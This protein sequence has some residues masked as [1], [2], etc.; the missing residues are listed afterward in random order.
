MDLNEKEKSILNYYSIF[1]FVS[2][3]LCGICLLPCY[4]RKSSHEFCFLASKAYS[5]Y[6]LILYRK[7]FLTTSLGSD[8]RLWTRVL[9][10]AQVPHCLLGRTYMGL[11]QIA[12][13]ILWNFNWYCKKKKRKPWRQFGTVSWT[14]PGWMPATIEHNKTKSTISLNLNKS[15]LPGGKMVKDPLATAGDPRDMGLIPRSGRSSGAGN[16]NPL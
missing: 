15:N 3:K 11:I 2:K 7:T 8:H 5:I 13:Q 4:R 14:N 12:L 9:T 6:Y 10:T 16:G 1:N